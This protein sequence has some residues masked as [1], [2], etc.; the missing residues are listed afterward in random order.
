[1][2]HAIEKSGLPQISNA[3]IAMIERL[4]TAV[5]SL[6]TALFGLWYLLG[7]S[8][9]KNILASVS[10]AEIIITIFISTAV[11]LIAA[12]SYSERKLW[13]LLCNFKTLK[14]ALP[15]IALTLG[16]YSFIIS[17]FLV[18]I[19]LT[20]PQLNILDSVAASAIISFSASIPISIGGWGLREVAAIFVLN[21]IGV[22]EAS[23]LTISISVGALST[24]AGSPKL[25]REEC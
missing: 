19:K 22:D 25:H 11:Y 17:C 21:H 18:A 24:L 5:L 3:I 10:F 16:S 2:Q 6:T 7:I 12:V 14:S 13:R 20:K 8:E 23:A 1:M 9:A 15:V 4:S